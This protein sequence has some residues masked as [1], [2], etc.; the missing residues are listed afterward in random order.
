[1]ERREKG[2][3]EVGRGQEGR[4]EGEGRREG[5]EHVGGGRIERRKKRSV[6]G[7]WAGLLDN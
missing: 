5:W 1:M 6:E 3:E 4:G 2:K 7:L